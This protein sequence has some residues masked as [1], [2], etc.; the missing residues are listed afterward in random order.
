LVVLHHAPYSSSDNH[1]SNATLQWPFQNW[2]ADVVFA[3]HDHHYERLDVAGV[4]Y[5]VSGLGGRSIYALGPP[6]SQSRFR[7]NADY[8]SMLVIADA[9]QITHQ[10][11]SVTGGGTLIDSFTVPAVSM[12]QPLVPAGA[13]WK[14]LDNGSNQG[15]AWRDPGFDDSSWPTGLAQLGYG[16]G[17]ES[18]VV[19]YG[20]STSSKYITTH[21][22]HRFEVADPSAAPSLSL[23]LLRD[24]GAIVY[25]N[26]IE[27][28]RTNLPAAPAIVS[29]QTLAST[30]IGNAAE[31]TWLQ[32][33]I[34]PC[35]LELGSNVIA[36]EVHQSSPT[37]SDLSFD[38]SLRPIAGPRPACLDPCPGDLDNS[39]VVNIDDLLLVIHLWGA[40]GISA[41]P[42]DVDNNGVVG[43]DDL[44]GVIGSWGEC[45]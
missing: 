4:P 38:L 5:F 19:S 26:G 3:G 34:H 11:W 15:I 16:E 39:T 33:A 17:D 45:S 24:D 40:T 44:L 9:D 29:H 41:A 32:V 42:A 14:Y 25:L 36:V 43:I 23:E 18:T 1:S 21:F 27:I 12:G 8:G 31:G 30:A 7:Y 37:S 22:R 6:L 35:L 20:P 28:L 2:G 10:F 13:S